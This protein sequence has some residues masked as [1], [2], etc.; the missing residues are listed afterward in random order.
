MTSLDPFPYGSGRLSIP[1]WGS[2]IIV[3]GAVGVLAYLWV[4]G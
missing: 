4:F 1:W 3:A 2:A